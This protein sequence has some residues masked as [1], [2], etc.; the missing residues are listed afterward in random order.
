MTHRDLLIG[1][2]GSFYIDRI[3]NFSTFPAVLLITTLFRLALSIS[4]SRLI[5][6]D[7]DA[8]RIVRTFGLFVIGDN[9]VVGFV[10]FGIVTIVQ[11]IV[12]TKGAERVAGVAA[13]FLLMLCLVNR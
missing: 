12:I 13:V 6:N 2:Y 5:L 4:T 1:I 11:F 8:G 3:L 9:L 7:A 10:I